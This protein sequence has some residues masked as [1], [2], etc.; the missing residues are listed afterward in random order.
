METLG[1]DGEVIAS[2]TLP[3]EPKKG[4]VI[5]SREDVRKA[6]G[7][8]E[9]LGKGKAA[10]VAA[11]IAESAEVPPI[12][13]IMQVRAPEKQPCGTAEVVKA[14][15]ELYQVN[16]GAFGT[17]IF[18][19]PADRDGYAQPGVMIAEPAEGRSEAEIAA[20]I[21]AHAAPEPVERA[22]ALPAPVIHPEPVEALGEAVAGEGEAIEPY[23][24]IGKLPEANPIAELLARVEALEARVEALPADMVAA[25]IA[26]AG[27]PARTAA[28]ERAIRRAW[29][30]RAKARGLRFVANLKRDQLDMANRRAEYFR[31][32]AEGETVRANRAEQ[33]RRR[34]LQDARR[35]IAYYRNH[36]RDWQMTAAERMGHIF[37]QMDKRTRADQRARRM[38]AAWREAERKQAHY[39]EIERQETHG[40]LMARDM[41]QA[42]LARV[43][44]SMADPMQP[45]RAS[46]I[47][48][49]IRER[50]EARTAAAATD[51]RNR[52]LQSAVDGLADKFEAMV[53]RVS[54]AEAALRAAGV[55][56][57]A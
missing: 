39:R 1:D 22:E 26:A 43:K 10:P 11:P 16:R 18:H 15:G 21:A 31:G 46:D 32:L 34:A 24:A 8:V 28:H 25:P 23:A 56:V 53:S 9:K 30:E 12:V 50:D 51:A 42:E 7:K 4:G 40:A 19:N 14:A 2:Q 52:A 3:V 33:K 55:T 48:Q 54:R 35:R 41:A 45:E 49:L 44:A 37:A 20:I 38:I 6:A 5:W 57:A 27:R 36:A 17:S 47:A 29:A 13:E